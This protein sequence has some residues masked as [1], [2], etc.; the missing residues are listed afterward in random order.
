MRLK[1]VC[2]SISFFASSFILQS[3]ITYDIDTSYN[4]ISAYKKYIKQYPNIEIADPI[5]DKNIIQIS[6]IVYKDLDYRKLHLD[7]IYN[8]D[9]KLKPAVI[10]VHGGGWKTGNKSL[11]KPMAKKIA[12]KGYAC[13]TVEYRL[14]LEAQFPAAIF[15]VKDA[16]KFVKASAEKFN[17][18][19]TKVA[20]L[21]SSAGGQITSLVGTTNNNPSFEDSEDDFKASSSV[22]AIIDIDGVLAFIHPNSE[23]DKVA[24]L[25]LGGNSEEKR[26]TWIQASALTHADE[27]TPPILFICSKHNRFHAGRDDMIKILDQHSIYNQ[28]E[29]FQ[30]AP[31]SFWLFHPWFNDTVE[32]ITTFLDKTFK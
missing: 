24:S 11:M 31:H 15:D 9:D 5:L 17:I 7:A 26:G 32:Y 25:W 18:D 29:T 3:Q 8:K 2:I 6:D 10:L 27:N 23:E 16:I 1:L 21:G 13:F 4:I 20:I 28:V 14:S 22:Q 12:A 19:S 30:D